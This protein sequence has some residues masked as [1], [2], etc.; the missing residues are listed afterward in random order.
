MLCRL[1][2]GS[3]DTTLRAWNVETGVCEQYLSGHVAAVR[4][5]Q[6]DLD[7]GRIVS[8]AY[9][10]TIKVSLRRSLLLVGAF[11]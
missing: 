6:F 10:F 11:F 3:R 8:G 4:C 2:S 1:V 9:D 7:D 5:V